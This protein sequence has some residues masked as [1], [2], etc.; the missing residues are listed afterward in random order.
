[1]K[2]GYVF[3]LSYSLICWENV[4]LASPFS[5][6]GAFL[7]VGQLKPINDD[8]GEEYQTSKIIGDQIDYQFAL[9]DFLSCIFFVSE[10]VN[11]GSVPSIKK[12]EYYK[13]GILGAELR[14]WVG[15]L[16]LG[17]HGGR[18]FLTWIETLSSYSGLKWSGGNG[19]G[20][21]VESESGW[22]IGWYKEK[23]G[24]I[25]FNDSPDQRVE[26]DRFIFGYRWR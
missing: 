3:L 15:P 12:Y 23:S 18:Y 10:N 7:D 11:K 1:M 16:F 22:S 5:G 4:L 17:F 13:A 14:A 6:W 9:G 20:L 26:G 21:G 25:K 24:K 2:L 19:L 8:S